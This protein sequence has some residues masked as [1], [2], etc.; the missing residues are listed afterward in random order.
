MIEKLALVIDIGTTFIEVAFLDCDRTSSDK[1]SDQ[2]ASSDDGAPDGKV[3][4][5][6]RAPNEQVFYGRDI[7][8]RL[9]HATSDGT[10]DSAAETTRTELREAAHRSVAAAIHDAAAGYE[11]KLLARC[12][13]MVAAGNTVMTQLYE[14]ADEHN[15]RVELLSPIGNF[16]GGDA[17]AAL[18]ATDLATVLPPDE[19]AQLLIDLGTNAEIMLRTGTHLYA[20]SVPAG[21][22]FEGV[23]AHANPKWRGTDVINHVA[24]YLHYGSIDASGR[25]VDEAMAAPFVQE[26]IRDFQLAK[27]AVCAGIEGLLAHADI[28]PALVADVILAGTFGLKMNV[29]AAASIGLFPRS[30][31]NAHF[32]A[33]CAPTIAGSQAN[34][35]LEGL[36]KVACGA[37]TDIEGTVDV[38]NLAA[39]DTFNETLLASLNF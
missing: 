32:T 5:Y 23:T 15:E 34:A 21:P 12:T 22:T 8:T 18:I 14:P 11:E 28:D 27:A 39:S 37:S 16:V 31:A 24:Q 1:T 38:I 2:A 10:D 7:L 29:E 26:D 9:T 36:R 30:L 17:R 3:V 25:I 4:A 19:P 35:V 20:T 6:G 13:R 33:F